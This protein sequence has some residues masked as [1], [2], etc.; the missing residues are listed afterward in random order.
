MYL[1][2]CIYIPLYLAPRVGTQSKLQT[3][4]CTTTLQ[5]SKQTNINKNKQ[6]KIKR[7]HH[8]EKQTGITQP[9]QKQ[10]K[11]KLKRKNQLDNA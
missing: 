6:T 7:A 2:K 5:A 9:K 10:K 11:N 8:K 4:I 3:D 1:L